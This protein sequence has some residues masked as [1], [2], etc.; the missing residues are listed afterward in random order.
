M[1]KKP[2]VHE[3]QKCPV[4]GSEETLVASLAAK[5]I[6]KGI[7]PNAIPHY[8]HAWPFVM[9]D[10]RQPIIIGS[11]SPAGTVFIDVCKGCGIIRAVRIEVGEAMAIARPP[12][13]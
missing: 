5:E 2:E 1:E 4:C 6:E 12:R 3:Y 8:L 7:N 13:G 10:P 11:R 9:R